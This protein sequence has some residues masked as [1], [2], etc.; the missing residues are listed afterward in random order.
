MTAATADRRARWAS[1]RAASANRTTELGL[2]VIVALIVVAAYTLASLGKTA[3]LPVNLGPFLAIILGLFVLGNVALRQFAPRADPVLLPIAGLL[4]GVGYVVIV[5]LNHKLAGLQAI[6]SLLGMGAFI[7]TIVVIRRVRDLERYRYLL[8]FG[9]V[10]LL[11]LP[12]VPGIGRTINGSRVWVHVGPLNFQPG[13]I[14]KVA[15][16]C[17]G[18]SYLAE[19]GVVLAQGDRHLGPI[20]LPDLRALGP[21]ALAWALSIVIMVA[22]H[23]LGM[24]LLYFTLF[25]TM[26]VVA[27]GRR[28]YLGAGVA[29][30]A[31]AALFAYKTSKVLHERVTVWIDP[32]KTAQSSGYQI[33]Q[34]MFAFGAGGVSG[35]G[36]ALGSPT[37]IPEVQTDFIFAAIGEELGFVG[38][39]TIL[40]GY[41]LIVGVGLRIAVRAEQPF[42]KLVA[43][44]ASAIFAL[45]TFIIVGGVTRLL[46]LTGITLPFVSYG[47]SSLLT[48]YVLLALL[49]RIS[50][51]SARAAA[52]LPA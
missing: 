17:F 33:V 41:L 7:G 9:G 48:N 23:E 38:T 24:G 14:A 18:A 45:Q 6:W 51:S 5:R 49:L 4:N 32:W 43:V 52:G 25:I 1:R 30:F 8:G 2:I 10:G 15:L 26:L 42:D 50:D 13:E 40:L 21:V 34:S 36:L 19:K 11:L 47:G 16:L 3:S 22:G 12:F 31:V 27:T 35:T 37:R 44:G 29:L 28:R 46:P 39:V 20:P